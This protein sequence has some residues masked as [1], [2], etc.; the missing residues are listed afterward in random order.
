[1]INNSIT[2]QPQTKY[3][4]YLIQ[5]FQSQID[6]IPTSLQNL[7]Y[8]I[9]PDNPNYND[10][11]LAYNKLLNYFPK[12]IFCPKNENDIAYLIEEFFKNKLK[13]AIRC[14]GH[15]YWQ[16]SLSNDY[17][18]DVLKLKKTI[19]V[20]QDRKTVTLSI[21]WKLGE[22]IEALGK[23]S[24]IMSSG[25]S[26]CL[27]LGGI[28]LS[29]GK[30]ILTRLYGLMCENIVAVKMVNYK[31]ELL[32]I[33][34]NNY[35]DLFWAVRGAGAGNFGV[36]TEITLKTYED[37]L[38]TSTKLTWEWDSKVAVQILNL[39]QKQIV[40]YPKNV[41]AGLLMNYNNS[42]ALISVSF[43][44]LGKGK[45]ITYY[46]NIFEQIG[47]PTTSSFSGLY[48][49]TFDMWGDLEKGTNGCFSKIKSSMILKP[50]NNFCINNLVDSIDHFLQSKFNC[51]YQINI[52]QFGGEVKN[53]SGCFAFKN[54]IGF[55]SYF[56]Q[57]NETTLSG[58]INKYMNEIFTLNQK[59]I[60]P[61]SFFTIIDYNIPQSEYMNAYFGN[62]TNR[63]IEIKKKYDPHNL[64]KYKQSIPIK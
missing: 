62:N 58:L 49:S 45:P 2:E 8:G 36:I 57:W 1:M 48:A 16:T 26:Y 19:S 30:G 34:K 42:S 52:H 41:W 23:K 28:S 56:S 12:A 5:N 50:I 10:L 33:D 35:P 43:Y 25:S 18:L 13:F 11:R 7:V 9:Y 44:V 3:N 61:Y 4:C 24:L 31:G 46:T 20:A 39:Y 22:V 6:S 29:G 53:G 54:A 37:I 64:F 63:L 14:G 47:D 60:S 38:L 17:V 40:T 27:G 15:G 51:N 32:Y 21:G 59:F 55:L